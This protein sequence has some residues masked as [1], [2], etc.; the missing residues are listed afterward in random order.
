MPAAAPAVLLLSLDT[1]QGVKAR[2]N[3]TSI[4]VSKTAF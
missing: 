4:I 1:Q 3:N 2:L